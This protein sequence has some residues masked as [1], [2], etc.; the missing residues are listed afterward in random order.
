MITI[1]DAG[2]GDA[3]V[4]AR[5]NAIVQDLHIQRRPDHFKP[6]IFSDLE[7]CYRALLEKPTTRA[8]VAE[9]EG[10]PVGYVLAVRRDQPETAF[11]KARSFL[12]VDQLAVAPNYRRQGIARSLVSRAI[13]YAAEAGLTSV[14][15]ATWS[16]NQEMQNLLACLGFVP[17][18]T[19]FER[20]AGGEERN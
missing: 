8:W 4:L 6:T 14:E 18:D 16:F 12:E 15:A 13:A 17:K 5:L 11:S 10:R 7:A 20:N 3:A 2:M 19:R 1:K 9:S